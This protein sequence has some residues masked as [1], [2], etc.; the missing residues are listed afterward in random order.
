MK[1]VINLSGLCIFAIAFKFTR[2]AS[3]G[4]SNRHINMPDTD[5]ITPFF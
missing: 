3:S 5:L 1:Q 2:R 4:L